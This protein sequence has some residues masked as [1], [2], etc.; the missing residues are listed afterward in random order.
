MMNDDELLDEIERTHNDRVAA[1]ASV[2][3]AH[4]WFPPGRC[5]CGFP[6]MDWWMWRGHVAPFIALRENESE[7][8]PV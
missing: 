6:T 4:Q 8:P 1:I 3:D 5:A 2:M 7:L